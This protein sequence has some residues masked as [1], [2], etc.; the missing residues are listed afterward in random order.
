MVLSLIRLLDNFG[1]NVPDRD[2][3][4]YCLHKQSSVSRITNFDAVQNFKGFV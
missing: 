1:V 2:K 3:E 4:R